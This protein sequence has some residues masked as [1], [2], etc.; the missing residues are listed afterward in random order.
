MANWVADATVLRWAELTVEIS[1]GTPEPL[2]PSQVI[3]A[4][5]TAPLAERDVQAA[6]RL[7][8]D[9]D[10]KVCVWTDRNL[11]E[12]FDVDHAIPFALWRNNDLWNLLPASTA[13]NQH[14]R[15]RLPSRSLLRSRRSCILGYWSRM[16]EAHPVRF[17]FEVERLA[18]QVSARGGDCGHRFFGV[19]AEAVEFTAL[20]RG[21]ER[22][23][24]RGFRVV[25]TVPE[26]PVRTASDAPG[27]AVGNARPQVISD[28]PEEERFITWVPYYDLAAAA[29]GFGPEQP[30]PDPST[31][32]TWIRIEGRRLTSDMF[33]I[34]VIGRSMEPK[35]PDGAICLFR[36]GDALAGSRQGRI[37]L[38][39][40]RDSVD[41]ETGGR[42]TVKRYASTKAFDDEGAF[43]HVR[44][45][46]QPI[47]PDFRPILVQAAD[48][49]ALRVLGEWLAVVR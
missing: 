28:P 15:D 43:R 13:A 32:P 9:L 5:L 39:A 45:E 10:G 18:G 23:E 17:D 40:L 24:P 6:R 21:V 41:P 34:R 1:R 7:Y 3:D 22:W 16:R 37:L 4:L 29:G 47:N 49:G 12:A 30:V 26:I 25:V 38:V 20:Q 33:A 31:A 2:Q 27:P 42:L 44:I 35:I 48:D 8:A 36:G 14:K 46:L 11:S 19:V